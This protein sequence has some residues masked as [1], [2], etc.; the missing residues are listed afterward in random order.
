[1]GHTYNHLD[2]EE[3][4]R[5]AILRAEGK[6]LREIARLLGRSHSTLVRDL[7]RCQADE[8][9][10]YLPFLANLKALM[11]QG[12][13]RKRTL[14]CPEIRAYVRAKIAL[15]WSPEQV[16]GRLPKDLPGFSISHE[17]IYQFVYF[18]AKDLI[19]C[20]PRRHKY[21]YR[22]FWNRRRKKS[23]IPNR[24]SILQR[25]E[26]VG[27]REEFG[28]WESDAVVSKASKEVLNVLVERKSRFVRM[29][30]LKQNTAAFTREAILRRLLGL[31]PKARLSLTYDNGSENVLHEAINQKL[32][33]HS[34]FCEPYHSWEKGTVEN[35]NGLIRRFIPKKTDLAKLTDAEIRKVEN[36]LNNR[37][38]KCLGYQTP[39]EVFGK[40]SGALQS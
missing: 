30:K 15:G 10:F 5:I 39:G 21:R 35:T 22:R 33:T 23:P 25:P 28:H 20:L 32:G 38:R 12:V 27:K 29:T 18:K 8:T 7:K 31:V 34:Y 14:K 36:L 3:R 1:M 40:L 9:G 17:A 2:L 37:P 16:S 11:K 6:S 24:T 26:P 4:E 19:P 13:I